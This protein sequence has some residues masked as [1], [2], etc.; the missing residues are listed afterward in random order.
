ME[1]INDS[2]YLEFLTFNYRKDMNSE[3]DSQ[4]VETITDFYND[5]I[6]NILRFNDGQFNVLQ[7]L[8]KMNDSKFHYEAYK[9]ALSSKEDIIKF[10]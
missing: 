4:K 1:Y 8:E 5:L 9:N 2:E 7:F 3:D 6:H 10:N